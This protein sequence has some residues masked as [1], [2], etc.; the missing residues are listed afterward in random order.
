LSKVK[1]PLFHKNQA[2]ISVADPEC[3]SQIPDPYLHPSPIPDLGSRIQDQKAATKIVVIPFF[4]ATNFPK[5]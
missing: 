3:L 5:L 1:V 2:K 4:V